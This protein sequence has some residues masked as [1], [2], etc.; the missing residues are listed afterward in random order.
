[1]QELKIYQCDYCGKTYSRK[2]DCQKCERLH[3][4]PIKVE[5]AQYLPNIDNANYPDH[6]DIQ[7][8]DGKRVRYKYSAEVD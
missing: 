8:S 4:H 3:R 6:V 1:M 7:M 5:S 2:G